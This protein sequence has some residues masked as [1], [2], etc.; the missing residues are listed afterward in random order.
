MKKKKHEFVLGAVERTISGDHAKVAK[1][2]QSIQSA[3]PVHRVGK[4]DPG[5]LFAFDCVPDYHQKANHQA[6]LPIKLE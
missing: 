6:E 1:R 5:T 3:G 2:I 4:H